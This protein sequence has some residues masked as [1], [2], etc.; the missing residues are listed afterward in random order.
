MN[1]FFLP[2]LFACI[3]LACNHVGENNRIKTTTGI[4][5]KPKEF[6]GDYPLYKS[7][8][9]K[10]LGQYRADPV[11]S[12][13]IQFLNNIRDS[14]FTCWLGTPWD[15]NG[16]TE[17]PNNGN[18]ACGYFVTTLLRDMGIKLNRVKLAQCASE[19]MIKTVCIETSIHRS[20]NEPISKFIEEIKDAGLYIVGLD[21]HT[22]FILNDG[23]NKY[24]IHANYT[25]KKVVEKE[26]AIESSVLASSK[27]KVIG[28]VI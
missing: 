22:G 20:R 28:K 7:K 24:F 6:V 11:L 8:S 18:I 4:S 13:K 21:F 3:F 14:L 17:E 19:E 23:K 10:L 26:I 15:F 25:G 9:Q 12:N 2:L 16:T 5:Q 1:G 27:Y